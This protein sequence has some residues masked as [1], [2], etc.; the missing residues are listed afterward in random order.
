[1]QDE[2][3]EDLSTLSTRQLGLDRSPTELGDQAAA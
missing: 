2:V 3:G 1:M